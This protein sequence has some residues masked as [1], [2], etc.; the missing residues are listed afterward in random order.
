MR[1]K[2]HPGLSALKAEQRAVPEAAYDEHMAGLFEQTVAKK[3]Y[4]YRSGWYRL[5]HLLSAV[6]VDVLGLNGPDDD[7]LH[8]HQAMLYLDGRIRWQMGIAK[9]RPS[10]GWVH[11]SSTDSFDDATYLKL[12]EAARDA[13]D[14]WTALKLAGDPELEQRRLLEG[15]DVGDLRRALETVE[16]GVYVPFRFEETNEGRLRLSLLASR[17]VG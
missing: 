11:R 13:L 10:R 5:K 2:R 6:A 14:F 7:Y 16:D 4:S 8:H 1:G 15:A 12:D 3:A 17:F 9:R